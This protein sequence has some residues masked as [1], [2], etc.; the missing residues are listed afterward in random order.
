MEDP[1]KAKNLGHAALN[2]GG[3]YDGARALSWLSEVLHPGHGLSVEEVRQIAAEV[4]ANHQEQKKNDP[5]AD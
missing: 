1:R 2:P 4:Q 5:K 3:T